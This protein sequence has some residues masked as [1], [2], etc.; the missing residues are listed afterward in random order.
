MLSEGFTATISPCGRVETL[1]E[2]L[3]ADESTREPEGAR[4]SGGTLVSLLYTGSHSER[5]RARLLLVD[6]KAEAPGADSPDHRGLAEATIGDPSI[7]ASILTR[8]AQGPLPEWAR[9]ATAAL[10]AS[11]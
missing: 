8:R 4:C 1:C 9:V 7:A 6:A 5:A 10:V 11:G 3:V 2:S